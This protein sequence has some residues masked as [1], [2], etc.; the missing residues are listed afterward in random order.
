V[1][2][3]LRDILPDA[4]NQSLFIE[5]AEYIAE[6]DSIGYTTRGAMNPMDIFKIQRG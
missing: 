6:R 2:A 5:E 3:K 1:W 4:L